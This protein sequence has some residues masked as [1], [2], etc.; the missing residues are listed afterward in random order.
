MSK[1]TVAVHKFSSCDGC[2]LAFLN[3]GEDLLKLTELVDIR[4]FLEAGLADENAQVDIA[5]V[6][7]SVSTSEDAAKLQR[8]R[9]NSRYLVTIGACATAGGLQALRNL[10]DTQAWTAAVYASPEHIDSLDQV[11]PIRA[12]VKVDQGD[13]VKVFRNLVWKLGWH[14][15]TK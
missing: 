13:G 1:P 12:V 3:L 15:D 11:S 2:Q 9:S 8:I 7:G 5:F 4:H 10:H 6:E 14:R